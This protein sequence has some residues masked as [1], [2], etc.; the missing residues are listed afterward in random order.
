METFSLS[1]QGG[2]GKL[3]GW[4]NAEKL[5]LGPLPFAGELGPVVW[6]PCCDVV[7]HVAK[8]PAIDFCQ[9]AYRRPKLRGE[10]VTH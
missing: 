3:K 7:Q 2:G 10:T 1:D 9:Q 8:V 5:T 6:P 4:I